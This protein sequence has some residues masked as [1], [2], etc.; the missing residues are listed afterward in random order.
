MSEYNHDE[1]KRLFLE[2]KKAM[3]NHEDI[4]LLESLLACE[5]ANSNLLIPEIL[6][7]GPQVLDEIGIN[8]DNEYIPLFTDEDELKDCENI[9]LTRMPF[10]SI[11]ALLSDK[12]KGI[13]INVFSKNFIL[14]KIEYLNE[15]F[16]VNN[17]D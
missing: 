10:R 1:L 12:V 4:T 2:I 13:S 15:Y 8:C 5:L 3:M 16:E 11:L 7:E 14:I 17:E 6:T 9:K